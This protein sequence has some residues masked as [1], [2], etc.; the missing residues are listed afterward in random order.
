[1]LIPRRDFLN[2]LFV[3]PFLAKL[4][5]G[6]ARRVPTLLRG[7]RV[8][9]GRSLQPR[10][11]G[12]NEAGRIVLDAT[13]GDEVVDAT[14]KII[15]PGFI[16]ILADNSRGV[17]STFQKYK[18][19]DG[20]ST[21]LELHG[22]TGNARWYYAALAQRR[23]LVNYGAST[24]LMLI[25]GRHYSLSGRVREARACLEAGALA[26]SH[27]IEYQ[28]TPFEEL[29]A[30]AQLAREYD[31]PFFLHL[32]HSDRA[33]ELDGVTEAIALA[34]QTRARVH[35]SHLHSTGGTF[36][37]EKALDLI[38]AARAEGLEITCCVYPYSRWATYL[39]STRFARGWQERYGLDYDDLTVVGTGE[40]LTAAKF[41]RYRGRHG[42]L[43]AVP[44]G[45]MPLD[46]TV[47]L[48][49]KEEF[50]LVGSDGGIEYA[51]HANSHPRGAGC[52]AT[53]LQRA[54]R[55][56]LGL[57]AMLWKLT[58]GPC[59]LL[60]PNLD[61]RGRIED[62]AWADLTVFDPAKVSSPATVENP[63]Q[64]SQGIDAVYVN[65]RMAYKDQ[66]FMESA[67]RAIRAVRTST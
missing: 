50:C 57:E 15:S 7:G 24:K 59:A 10:D 40:R 33:R 23:Q 2:Q 19:S 41:A 29:V 17:L 22:G 16:D 49:L 45:S 1:M 27:S 35:I 67:G 48:A 44:E 25:R 53:A 56:G 21:A 32:R 9:I 31:R 63:N 46:R 64:Y 39:A 13:E 65:G 62:G 36:A 5:A 6:S 20:V 4:M 60:R 12:I 42:L 43:V 61:G 52:F 55:T 37:M 11:V 3:A 38:R 14:G 51:R 30:Y 34:R 8:F 58:E 66:R 18:I 26:V 28:P 47:D 54:Q